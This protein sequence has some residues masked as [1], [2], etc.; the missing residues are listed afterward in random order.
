MRDF[1]FALRLLYKSPAFTLVAV[2][3]LALG[4]GANT[5]IFSVVNSLLLRPLPYRD[6][7]RLVNIFEANLSRGWNH[8]PTSG[9]TFM[10]WKDEA[11]S[12]SDLLLMERGSA[13][14]TGGAEPE[15]IPGLRVTANF[16]EMLGAQAGLGRTF[17]PE[18][19]HG[20]RHNAAVISHAYWMRRFGGDRSVV[21]RT[22]TADGLRYT[23]IGVLPAGFWS[24]MPADIFVPWPEEELRAKLYFDRSLDAVGLL[25]PGVSIDQARAELNTIQMRLAGANQLRRSW[26]IGVLP[27]Q[28]VIVQSIRPALLILLAA[29]GF[30]LLIACANIANL[31]LARAARRE[32]EI[33]IRTAVGASR[34]RIVRQMLSESLLLGAMGGAAGF[35]LAMWG[36]DLLERMIPANI[37]GGRGVLLRQPIAIDARVLAFTILTAAGTAILFGLAPALAASK[38]ARYVSH[39]RSRLRDLLVISE[40]AL[41]LTLLICA[42][43]TLRSFANMLHASPGFRAEQVLTLETEIPTDTKRTQPQEQSDFYRRVIDRLSE[44]P[45]V[46]AAG[47]TDVLPL[48]EQDSKVGFVVDGAPPLPNGERLSADFR[49]VSPGYF[50][51]M[52]IP[53]RQGRLFTDHDRR[54]APLAAIVDEPLVRRYLPANPIGRR[55]KVGDRLFEIVGVAGGVKHSGLQTEPGPTIYAHYAQLPSPRMNIAVRTTATG[56]ATLRPIKNAIYSVDPDQPVYNVRTMQQI[57]DESAA[58][59]KMTLALLGLF[60]MVALTLASIG[61]YGVMSYI[62]GQRTQEIG[63]RMALGAEAGAIVRM[64]LAYG[65]R[66]A[67]AGV[68]A[69]LVISYVAARVIANQLYGVPAS[70]PGVLAGASLTLLAVALAACA[71]PA[72]RAARVDPVV[73]L[74]YQ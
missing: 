40:V 10:H 47:V 69:G 20:A 70:D 63:I 21:G 32:P 34:A 36:V 37:G 48:D 30:V 35:V 4:I 18:E 1:R 11:R 9:S 50:A 64:T 59:R 62:V 39:T 33:A 6:S 46:A 25:K 66:L 45:G 57:V 67:L 73:S 14:I 2:A 12:F 29:V 41:A 24:P 31:L 44:I 22:V 58:P 49:S 52:G 53:L 54:G 60:A 15:Q 55:V 56:P 71:L 8:F 7:G 23:V 72:R 16:F 5:A 51:A 74:R 26:T 43:L 17:Q 27:L 68:A 65:L 61:I 3:A 38:P 42:G 28:D 13:S 19:G